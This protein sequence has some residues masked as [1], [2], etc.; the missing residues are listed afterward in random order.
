MLE[1]VPKTDDLKEYLG[2]LFGNQTGYVYTG[3]RNPKL[4]VND[5]GYWTQT[6]FEWPAQA[7]DIITHLRQ[8]SIEY[9]TYV[10]PALFS[11][12]SS[13]KAHIKGSQVV[14]VDLDGKLPADLKDCPVPSMVVESSNP[15]NKKQHWYWRLEEFVTD[16][17][18]IER[19]NRGLAYLLDADVSGWDANQVL[20]PPA[21]RNH[22]YG[23]PQP[24]SL[25][26]FTPYSVNPSAFGAIPEAPSI[27]VEFNVTDLQDAALIVANYQWS[28]QAFNLYRSHPHQLTNPEGR[29]GALMQ[30]AY[31]GAEMG[32]NDAEIFTILYHADDRWGKFRGRPDRVRRLNDIIAKARV[33]HPY[34]IQSSLALTVLPVFGFRDFLSTEIRVEWVIPDFLEKSGQL[35]LSAKPG[36]GK[37]RFSLAFFIKMALGKPFLHYEAT[38][39]QKLIYFSLEMGHAQLMYFVE[40]MAGSLS[41]EEL[42]LLQENLLLVPLGEALYLDK[43]AGQNLVE[44]VLSEREPDGYAF[45]SLSRTTPE[46]VNDEAAIKL[47]LDWDAASR[48]RRSMF[49]WYIH[50]NRKATAANK[51]PKSLD[52]VLG[53]TVIAANTTAVY[54]LWSNDPQNKS[55]DVIC[56][57]QR[58]A[59]MERTYVITGNAD[60]TYSERS[61]L[62][63]ESFEVSAQDTL[64][65]GPPTASQTLP[66]SPG[67]DNKSLSGPPNLGF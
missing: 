33:K 56:T 6:F 13:Q 47:I 60:L 19:L 55:I 31:F 3:L 51:K 53:A 50:H 38:K 63:S 7:Q 66:E 45:D 52:D 12:P 44:K 8:N 29:S 11:A 22:K 28:K 59:E 5:K 30:L 18:Q 61:V 4:E 40:K 54:T 27:P 34:Q 62:N 58:L 67:L 10:A 2:L 57:K 1:V 42:D 35:L 37:S 17:K 9:D 36:I 26:S 64:G 39:P 14:W 21:T 46:T 20:R 24:V 23:N 25:L 41:P 48:N 49:S 65:L 43:R 32:M 15:E 16:I